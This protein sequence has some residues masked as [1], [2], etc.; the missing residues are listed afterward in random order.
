M[1]IRIY[2]IHTYSKETVGSNDEVVCRVRVK[3]DYINDS[4]TD[5]NIKVKPIG[6]WA[7]S[8]AVTVD[9][10]N[11]HI[12]IL[13]PGDERWVMFTVTTLD[14]PSKHWHYFAFSV[15]YNI[16]VFSETRK[17]L[18]IHSDQEAAV[19]PQPKVFNL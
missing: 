5:L 6:Q 11:I 18:Y 2:R 15:D 16:T 8:G 3:N 9:P 10:G 19:E 13:G 12:G 4:V 7:G 1:A 14:A 17:A